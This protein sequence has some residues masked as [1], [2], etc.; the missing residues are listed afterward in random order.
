MTNV[1]TVRQAGAHDGP[2]PF[3]AE[4]EAANLHPL[5]DRFQRITPAKPQATGAEIQLLPAPKSVPSCGGGGD[6]GK[7]SPKAAATRTSAAWS[8]TSARSA[9]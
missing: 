4:L 9:R 2:T 3:I 1:V 8:S 7:P 6:D 5:W